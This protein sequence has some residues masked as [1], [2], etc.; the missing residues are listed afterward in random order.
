MISPI[1]YKYVKSLYRSYNRYNELS[2]EYKRELAYVVK[3]ILS[4][5]LTAERMRK[6]IDIN[7]YSYDCFKEI[8]SNSYFTKYEVILK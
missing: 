4:N 6:N 2:Y 8:S 5:E 3:T 1:D 7:L